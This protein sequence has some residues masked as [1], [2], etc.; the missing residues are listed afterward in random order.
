MKKGIIVLLIALTML[1]VIGCEAKEEK[2]EFIYGP[3]DIELFK[4]DAV[5][6][7]RTTVFHKGEIVR[8]LEMKDK[9]VLEI[10]N[11]S[12]IRN[13]NGLINESYQ[14]ESFQ[15]EG[16]SY[17][18]EYTDDTHILTLILEFEKIDIE[19]MKGKEMWFVSEVDDLINE[20]F[21]IVYDKVVNAMLEDGC[22]SIE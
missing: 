12:Y 11:K 15:Y 19:K 5:Q 9:I 10:P 14:D 7:V 2:S 6:E 13:Y 22:R 16:F 4:G 1:C 17:S 21:E 18:T 20:N 3:K 8:K